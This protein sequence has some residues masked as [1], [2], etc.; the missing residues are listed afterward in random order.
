VPA[1][2]APQPFPFP[3]LY[4]WWLLFCAYC[5]F[6]GWAL[7]IVHALNRLGYCIVFFPFIVGSFIW[8]KR[9]PVRMRWKRRRFR[10]FLPACFLGLAALVFCGGALYDPSNFDGLAYR[11]PRVLHW[12]AQ[13]QW[14]WIHT[15][16]GRL[17]SRAPAWEWITA[18]LMAFTNSDRLFFLINT[19]CFLFL[20]GRLFAIFS[21]L[22]V[23]PR[24]AYHWMWLLPAGY[25]YSLQAGSI[26]TDL[27]CV[28]CVLGAFEFALRAR[29]SVGR[30]QKIL[31]STV[32]AALM[33]S[34]K[35]FNLL[36]VPPW[37]LL[38]AP[39]VLCLRKK[40]PLTIATIGL[41]VVASEIPTAILN[42]HYCGDWTGLKVEPVAFGGR[43]MFLI[44]VNSIL[45]TLQNFAPPIFPI[46]GLWQKFTATAIPPGLQA[47][48]QKSFE[49][50][51]ARFWIGEMPSEENGGLGLAVSVLLLGILFKRRAAL[52]GASTQ[53]RKSN[54][55]VPGGALAAA[56]VIMSRSGL[57]QLARYL[58]P[59]YPLL[60][61]PILTRRGSRMVLQRTWWRI[62][63]LAAFLAAAFV[64]CMTPA[65]PLVPVLT[66]LG[67][68]TEKGAGGRIREVYSIYRDR[69]TAFKP[70]LQ[71]LPASLKIVGF[72]S[73]DELEAPLWRPYGS[74]RVL[75]LTQEDSPQTM[76]ER[77]I[78][79]IVVPLGVR[80]AIDQW[81]SRTP[82]EKIA[83]A[84]IRF[85]AR[86]KPEEWA[87]FRVPG[88][89]QQSRP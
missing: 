39:W 35:A 38:I 6:A 88:A 19:V 1:E 85:V 26:C 66:F 13:E 71:Q 61:V 89:A 54:W 43:P 24:V 52:G 87:I 30:P 48:L 3:K 80:S 7:S 57:S 59:F 36:L 50:D 12:L 58:L 83:R 70:I 69:P 82:L 23:Q 65:R 37:A 16:A 15:E 60:I 29:E 64:V 18:P 72:F 81:L 73:S 25:G 46:A 5:S 62:G 4:A 28:N 44:A 33:T 49:P 79:Y 41:A 2:A 22:G 53:K 75:H 8:F 63:S 51:A 56:L 32:A 76:R 14:H 86:G 77:G 40:L 42:L 21:R 45:I 27:F 31:V 47:A 9:Q 68:L 17:N 11:T 20:P 78:E 67:P 74:R 84:E 55:I 10:R 34:A